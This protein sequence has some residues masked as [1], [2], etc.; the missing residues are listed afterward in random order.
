MLN[1][2]GAK[3]LLPGND[4]ILELPSQEEVVHKTETITKKIQ[5]LLQTAQEGNLA[6]FAYQSFFMVSYI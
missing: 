2:A 1:D 6:R 5:E 3:A 4:A